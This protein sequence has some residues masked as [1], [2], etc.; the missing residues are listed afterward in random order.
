MPAFARCPECGRRFRWPATTETAI[1][2]PF[3]DAAVDVDELEREDEAPPRRRRPPSRSSAKTLLILGLAGCGMLVLLCAGGIGTAVWW[4]T[5]ATSFPAQTEDYAQARQHFQTRLVRQAPAPQR[6]Q[7]ERPPAG[8]REVPYL[9]GSLRLRAWV[10]GPPPDGRKRPAVLFLHGGFAFGADDWEQTL[11]FQNAGFVVMTPT[12]RGE[13]G[14]PGSY[15]MFYNEVEDVLAAAETLAKLSYVD[16]NRIY[17]SGHSVGGTLTL[18]ASMTAKRFRAAASFSG[19]PDQVAWAR[20]Q[21]QLVPFDPNDQ[22]E[23]QMRSPLAF[24][25]SFK[26]PVRLYYGSQEFLF[27]SSSQKT[28]KLAKAAGLDVEAVSVPGDHFTMVEP[29]MRQAIAFF[30]QK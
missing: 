28:A 30:Q 11:P 21:S 15:S 14:L 26:C 22:R 24:P 18:L 6:W 9:S 23:F 2:C 19:S 12:L 7:M 5:S 25:G 27:A 4:F 1:Y 17:I 3:C 29:A 10:S 16:S 8:A 20:G 13:N